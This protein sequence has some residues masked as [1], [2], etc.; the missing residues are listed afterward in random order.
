MPP[1]SDLKLTNV[2]FSEETLRA[3]KHRAVELGKPVSNL[4]REAVEVYMAEPAVLP[5][6][7]AQRRQA[8]WLESLIGCAGSSKKGPRDAGLNH[9]HY[10]YGSPK[11]FQKAKG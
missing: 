7:D 10:L 4:V 6:K 5:E 2:R 9:D 8:K 1:R 3:L 11:K